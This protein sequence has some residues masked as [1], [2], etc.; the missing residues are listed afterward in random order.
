MEKDALYGGLL[1]SHKSG[2]LH[3]IKALDLSAYIAGPFGCSLL[4]DLGADV[5][6][7]EP[8]EGDALR[9]YPSTLATESRAFLGINRSKLGMVLDLKQ[10]DGLAAL[11]RLVESAD[12]LVH[13][14]RPS[15]PA[16]LGIDYARLSA[17]NPRIIYCALTGYG[18]S[19]PLRDKAGYDQVLQTMTGICAF[20]G[21]R[22]DGEPELVAGSVVDYYAAA[23]LAMS[24][25]AA[26]FQR[27]R[28]GVG[29]EIG[30]SLLGSSLAMQAARFVWAE[31][32][33]RNVNREMTAGGITGIYPTRDGSLYVQASAPHFWD[34]LCELTGLPALAAD[35]RYNT[36][37]KRAEHAAGL[38]PIIREALQSRTAVEWEAHFGE[39]VP[40]AAARHIEDMFD[41]AQVMA[42]DFVAVMEHPAVGRYRALT[43]PIKFGGTPCAPAFG[44]PTLGE[45]SARVLAEHGYS[46]DEI[47]RLRAIGVIR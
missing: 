14:F 11:L 18:G 24:I 47:A 42:Q 17:I 38:V 46:A 7:I 16:R 40:C 12:V 9:Q 34:A 28:S 31:G 36:L 37:R 2:P 33:P 15:V 27:E 25:T 32:E 29:Q 44:A 19:G 30:V 21:A 45:H 41:H 23:M 26:L 39:R 3:G 43:A 6:K 8:P 4:A 20:Q 10:P 22:R 35:A 5:I 13:N 1:E